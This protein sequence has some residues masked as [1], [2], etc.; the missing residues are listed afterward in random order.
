M[1][2]KIGYGD[3]TVYGI[4]DR[5]TGAIV[6]VGSCAKPLWA[7]W[8]QHLCDTY[9][10]DSSKIQKLIYQ[11]PW[12]FGPV[13]LEDGIVCEDQN[14]LRAIEQGYINLYNPRYNMRSAD[15][16]TC[17]DLK[18]Q[19]TL[20]RYKVN[21]SEMSLGAGD[22]VLAAEED[23]GREAVPGRGRPHGVGPGPP[24]LHLADDELHDGGRQRSDGHRLPVCSPA[25]RDRPLDPEQDGNGPPSRGNGRARVPTLD[26]LPRQASL[27]QLTI[28]ETWSRT[29]R[30]CTFDGSVPE[31]D[32]PAKKCK[33]CL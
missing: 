13:V 32:S 7:R 24:D 27:R 16:K 12:E 14:A 6:Y 4:E 19:S 33:H 15:R 30:R 26:P 8:G 25:R 18:N 29:P 20:D 28:V 11:R 2:P 22:D 3:C 21:A 17:C 1:P 31:R 23:I 5:R 10:K 9:Y